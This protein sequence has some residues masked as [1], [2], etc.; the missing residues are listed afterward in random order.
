[1]ITLDL[2]YLRALRLAV[3]MVKQ[4]KAYNFNMYKSV[5]I[6]SE[7]DAKVYDLLSTLI[8]HID[9]ILL[10]AKNEKAKTFSIMVGSRWLAVSG[11]YDDGHGNKYTVH[12]DG[13][14]DLADE[15]D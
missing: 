11:V 4:K 3:A 7:T 15:T 13:D 12:A 8:V 9:K 5:G 10:E 6:G 14:I 2:K 1:M